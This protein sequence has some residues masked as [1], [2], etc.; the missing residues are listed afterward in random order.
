[1]IVRILGDGQYE[2]PTTEEEAVR[3]LDEQLVTAVDAGDEAAFAPRLAEVVARIHEVGSPVPEEE[4]APSDLVVPFADAS[5][6]E[7]LRLL[8]QEAGS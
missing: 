6:E 4:F 3:A 2:V 8:D 5:L 1:M 7:T